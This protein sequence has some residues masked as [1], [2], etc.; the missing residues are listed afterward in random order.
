[1]FLKLLNM[2][3]TRLKKNFRHLEGKTTLFKAD[4]E[5]KNGIKP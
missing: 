4:P 3:K 5:G 1:V 2:E